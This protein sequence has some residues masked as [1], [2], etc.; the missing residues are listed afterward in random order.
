[1]NGDKSPL[2]LST[3]VASPGLE[4]RVEIVALLRNVGKV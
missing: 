3:D 1:M 4:T 2:A